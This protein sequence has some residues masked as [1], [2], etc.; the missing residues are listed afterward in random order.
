MALFE[1]V[2]PVNTSTCAVP[3]RQIH[4]IAELLS[5]S[6]TVTFSRQLVDNFDFRD[7]YKCEG[8]F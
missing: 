5:P 1:G 6:T 7:P 4:N 3:Q 2:Q 8:K